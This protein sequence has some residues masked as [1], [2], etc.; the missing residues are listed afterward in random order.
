MKKF[1]SCIR[2]K[3]DSLALRA[4]TILPQRSIMMSLHRSCETGNGSLRRIS[5]PAN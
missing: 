4:R 2:S 5:A 3:A 1:T